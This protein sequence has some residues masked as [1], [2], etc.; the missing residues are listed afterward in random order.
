MHSQR[1]NEVCLDLYLLLEW[2]QGL[3]ELFFLV[4]A[5]KCGLLCC[6]GCG[7]MHDDGEPYMP[8]GC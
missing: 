6:L 5:V 7:I 1:L 8:S 2:D 4:V 3:L